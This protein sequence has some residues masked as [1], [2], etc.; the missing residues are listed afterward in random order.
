MPIT[1]EGHAAPGVLQ[2]ISTVDLLRELSRRGG[3][4]AQVAEAQLLVVRKSED[5]NQQGGAAQDAINADRD[6]YFP[7]GLASHVQ[8]I[9]VK[10]QRLVSLALRDARGE[11]CNFEGVRDTSLDIIN[12]GSFLAE[13]ML[14]DGSRK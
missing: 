10:A 3:T 6:A 2:S 1:S 12:Y 14:R 7:F 9:H 13:W 11:G 8:M 5:Y 4:V